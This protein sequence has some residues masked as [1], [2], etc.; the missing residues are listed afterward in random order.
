[1]GWKRRSQAVDKKGNRGRH[2]IPGTQDLGFYFLNRKGAADLKPANIF[3][4]GGGNFKVG[5]LGLSR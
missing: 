3:I 5:D 1:M 2:P 4:D